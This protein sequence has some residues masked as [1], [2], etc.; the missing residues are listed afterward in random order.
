MGL[1]RDVRG[2]KKKKKI[3]PC[4]QG[5][6]V[7]EK[8]WGQTIVLKQFLPYFP[9]EESPRWLQNHSSPFRISKGIRGQNGPAPS[10]PLLT[11][12][13]RSRQPQRTHLANLGSYRWWGVARETEGGPTQ[14]LSAPKGHRN[15][16]EKLAKRKAGNWKS[17]RLLTAERKLL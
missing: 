16:T 3:H 2:E 9:A 6:K 15:D 10:P 17:K 11:K 1:C 12:V 5:I 13:P 4:L 14:V 7:R 8:N